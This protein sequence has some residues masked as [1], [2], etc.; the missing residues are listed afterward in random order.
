MRKYLPTWKKVYMCKYIEYDNVA[1]VG[2]ALGMSPSTVR[3]HIEKIKEAG[4]F[5]KYKSMDIAP[6]SAWTESDINFLIENYY[7]MEDIEL[8]KHLNRTQEA[9][10]KKAWELR[11]EGKLMKKE[12]RWLPEDDQYLIENRGKMTY[13]EIGEQLDRTVRAIKNR[14][15]YL[16]KQGLIER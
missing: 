14:V 8:A 12:F 2:L 11:K 3:K 4:L 15:L 13:K 5:E 6:Y 1:K 16:K 10:R 7:D 9:I